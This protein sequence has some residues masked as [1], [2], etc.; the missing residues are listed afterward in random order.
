MSNLLLDLDDLTDGHD[1]TQR[2][3]TKLYDEI[4]SSCHNKIKKCSKEFKIQECL[5]S[6]PRFVV[7]KPPYNYEE[8]VNYLLQSL[9]NN[10]LKV[11]W[12]AARDAIYIS[13]KPE[14]VNL[15]AYRSQVKSTAYSDN[16][17]TEI[18][19]VRPKSGASAKSKSKSKAT[20]TK[21]AAT[22]AVVEYHGTGK[23]MV[24]IN[25]KRIR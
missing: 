5:F 24:P 22:V 2:N 13:W 19:I 12:I 18:Q 3:K 16:F 23:D 4:L 1:R 14:D 11:E 7:G 21:P 25:I 10:G 15:D 6:P 8:L 20:T 9:Q 17:D